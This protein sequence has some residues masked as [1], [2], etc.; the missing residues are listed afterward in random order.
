MQAV[1]VNP[2]ALRS[3]PANRPHASPD[4]SVTV[5]VETCHHLPSF[6][7][8]VSFHQL[9]RRARHCC[10]MQ[11]M[12]TCLSFRARRLPTC[13]VHRMYVVRIRLHSFVFS[14]HVTVATRSW[15]EIRIQW[16]TTEQNATP[17]RPFILVN[18]CDPCCGIL[19]TG[20][21]CKTRFFTIIY[22]TNFAAPTDERT[23][24]KVMHDNK[25]KQFA[26]VWFWLE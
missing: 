1:F 9:N 12:T 18:N 26:S 15:G 8:L 2:S 25:T 13:L 10:G 20:A 6:G 5:L 24:V 16:L 3:E 22:W 23:L 19:G 11:S 21:K 7:S 4:G 14:H 17:A